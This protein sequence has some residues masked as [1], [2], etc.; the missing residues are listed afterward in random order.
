MDYLTQLHHVDQAFIEQQGML[1]FEEWR[2]SPEQPEP[3]KPAPTCGQCQHYQAPKILK[4]GKQTWGYCRLRAEADI[5][6]CNMA[7]FDRY[8]SECTYY[9]KEVE[10]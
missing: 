5:H 4:S 9:T 3:P 7:P 1:D 10:F 2:L 8:A 6:P